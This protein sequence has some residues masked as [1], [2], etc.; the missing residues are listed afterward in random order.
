MGG[1]VPYCTREDVMRAPEIKASA[2]QSSRIDDAIEQAARSVDSLCN[3]GTLEVRPGFAP[4][5][6]SIT[7]DWPGTAT[8]NN[9]SYRYWL[10]QDQLISLTSVTT[11]GQAITANTYGWTA[12]G[13]AP[14]AGI[15]IDRSSASILQVGSAAGQR[16]L[17]IT[18][19]WGY[20][21]TELARGT[22][23]GAI[24][25]SAT[26]A[27]L[28]APFG[29][30]S[31][32]RLDSERMV[33]TDRT[34]AS[35]GQTCTLA[36]SMSVQTIAVASGAAF[37]AGEE[38]LIDAE[39]VLITSIAGNN[40]IVTRAVNGSTLAAHTTATI[41]WNRTAT[42]ERGIL[43]TTAASHADGATVNT[44]QAPRLIKQLAIAYAIDQLQQENSAYAR[45]IGAAE[46]Q[47][48]FLGRGLK[49][50][51]QRVLNSPYTRGKVRMRAV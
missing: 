44:W 14:Y 36:A 46:S 9:S 1:F 41:F 26:S 42:L 32:I 27:L 7:F 22:L 11:D 43:G 31:I 21:N 19:V 28:A 39:R 23:S 35:T 45:S 25:A 47:S 3:R 33:V 38:L 13:G 51:E 50:L 18:G 40:L 20:S 15:E 29:V 10:A 49:A 48:E 34:W 37:Y 6:G 5:T 30:G 17:V 8:G 4:W 24:N 16:S 12:N 2:N